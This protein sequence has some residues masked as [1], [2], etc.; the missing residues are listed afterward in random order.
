MTVS[1]LS[2]GVAVPLPAITLLGQV[3]Q[4]TVTNA[5]VGEVWVSL[6]GSVLV[7]TADEKVIELE[8]CPGNCGLSIP[9]RFIM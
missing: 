6:K 9:E 8:P 1:V 7:L 4:P 2:D 3:P 5:S